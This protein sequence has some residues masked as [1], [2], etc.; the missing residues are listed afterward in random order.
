VRIAAIIP[1]TLA[2]DPRNQVR[3]KH[4][5]QRKQGQ[6]DGGVDP[7]GAL[8]EAAQLVEVA[9]PRVDREGEPHHDPAD[10]VLVDDPE[11]EGPPVEADLGGGEPDRGDRDRRVADGDVG[12]A[13]GRGGQ[14]EPGDVAQRLAVEARHRRRHRDQQQHRGGHG[15]D[16]GAEHDRLGVEPGQRHRH[17]RDRTQRQRGHFDQA[18]AA[19]VEV[20]PEQPARDR[21]E[22]GEQ[23]DRRDQPQQLGRGLAEEL[24]ADRP[25]EDEGGEAEPAA[26]DEAGEHRRLDVGVVDLLALDQG[27]AQALEGED[28]RQRHEDQRHHRLAELGRRDEARQ[29]HR[30][31]QRGQLGG[32]PGDHRPA[33]A[34][35]RGL[36]EVVRRKFGPLGIGLVHWCSGPLG[37]SRNQRPGGWPTC[38]PQAG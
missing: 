16:E 34:G 23:E 36:L 8:V 10:L 33:H 27:A 13:G 28:H 19:E 25:G 18:D 38:A 11:L 21:A 37:S 30:R 14:A 5:Q 26:G 29:D 1:A 32:D 2:E 6:Q 22:T 12:E 15:R 4:D 7:G 9:G 24:A 20:A 31:D 3:R 35:D 17:R